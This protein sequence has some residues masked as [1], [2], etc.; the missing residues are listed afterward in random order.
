MNIMERL[1]AINRDGVEEGE[2]YSQVEKNYM[3]LALLLDDLLDGKILLD[4][5]RGEIAC[6]LRRHKKSLHYDLNWK[7]FK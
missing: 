4:N 2:P 3:E 6:I 7:K 1:E 5:H